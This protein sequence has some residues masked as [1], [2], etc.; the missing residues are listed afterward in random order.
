MFNIDLIKK[1]GNEWENYGHHRVYFDKHLLAELGGL[2]CSFYN[3]GNIS[4]A[5]LNGEVISNARAK[6]L[7]GILDSVNMFFD[8]KN[9][10]IMGRFPA[11]TASDKQQ[12]L[13]NVVKN[14]KLKYAI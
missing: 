9:N 6:R 8:V 11:K 4:S 7:F 1:E 10:K 2:E 5:A 13:D 14:L 3:T 12:F